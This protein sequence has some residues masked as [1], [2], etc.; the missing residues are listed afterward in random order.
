[1]SQ[2]VVGGVQLA[3]SESRPH[4]L[5]NSLKSTEQPL[6]QRINLASHASTAETQVPGASC[7]AQDALGL[8][9]QPAL[10]ESQGLVGLGVLGLLSHSG[11]LYSGA[12][13]EAVLTFSE[14]VTRCIQVPVRR[15]SDWE[16][17]WAP[18]TREVNPGLHQIAGN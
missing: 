2:P 5:L 17:E 3:F 16:S 7:C 6:W 14:Q 10:F 11:I 4:M 8:S 13:S 18:K 1:M 15:M 9:P 12:V